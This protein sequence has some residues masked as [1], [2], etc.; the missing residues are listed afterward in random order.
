MALI[1]LVLFSGCAVAAVCNFLY[2]S[3]R[4]SSNLPPWQDSEIL[5][6]GVLFLPVLVAMLFALGAVLRGA[7]KWPMALIGIGSLP[8]LFLSV[9]AVGAV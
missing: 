9:M 2:F 6:F 5:N 4:A 7:P 3:W 8:L 1:A